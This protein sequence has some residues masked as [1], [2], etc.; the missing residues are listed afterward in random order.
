[1]TG[2]LV[3]GR[4]N[5]LDV[6]LHAVVVHPRERHRLLTRSVCYPRRKVPLFLFVCLLVFL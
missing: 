1:M 5:F 6:S 2:C 3:D 4:T